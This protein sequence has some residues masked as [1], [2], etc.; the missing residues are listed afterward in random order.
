MQKKHY[1]I[2]VKGRVQ[3]VGFR[4]GAKNKADDLGIYGYAKNMR[5]GSVVIEAEGSELKLQEFLTWCKD[6]S[7]HA[8]VESVIFEEKGVEKYRTFDI[9]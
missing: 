4:Y 5:D 3:G 9:Y 2:R 8:E 6:G 7:H 1:Q